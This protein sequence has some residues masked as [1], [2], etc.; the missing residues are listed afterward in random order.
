MFTV[1]LK[2]QLLQT[3]Q[4]SAKIVT[5]VSHTSGD[6]RHINSLGD[7]IGTEG[8]GSRHGQQLTSGTVWGPYSSGPGGGERRERREMSRDSRRLCEE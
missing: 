3:G 1:K 7:A 2:L 6:E 5:A 8:G 4:D